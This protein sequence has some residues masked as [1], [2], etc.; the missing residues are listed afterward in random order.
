LSAVVGLPLGLTTRYSGSEIIVS[1]AR[2]I[3][4]FT[5]QL[6]Q[7]YRPQRIVLFGSHAYG[8]PR[9]DSDVDLLVVMPV[10]GDPIDTAVEM[11]V[12]L[13]PPFPLDLLVRTPRRI[14]ERL[15]L[16]DDFIHDVLAKGKVLY[17]APHR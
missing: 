6:A 11:R 12:R 3:R 9:R 1:R 10:R 16:G 8:K 7:A 5:R 13:R 2:Q 17:E 14:R 4:Q 15:A